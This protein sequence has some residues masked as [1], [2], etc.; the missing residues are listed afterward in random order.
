[1]I[2]FPDQLDVSETEANFIFEQFKPS[3]M[4]GG[5]E[6]SFTY[7]AYTRGLFKKE[8][9]ILKMTTG[10]VDNGR[11]Y[12]VDEWCDEFWKFKNKKD[13]LSALAFFY[14]RKKAIE[15]KGKSIRCGIVKNDGSNFSENDYTSFLK[16]SNY[17]L[18]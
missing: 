10:D 8:Y 2:S 5:L 4:P 9:Y 12:L 3:H 16:E 13:Q 1:M 11:S 15:E 7:K 14:A 17:S 6:F 18:A